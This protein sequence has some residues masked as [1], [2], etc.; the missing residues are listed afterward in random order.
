MQKM[1]FTQFKIHRVQY[2]ISNTQVSNFMLFFFSSE[3]G[4][5]PSLNQFTNKF[6]NILQGH[7]FIH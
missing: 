4:F 3:F 1:M 2:N 7:I 6:L 5:Y